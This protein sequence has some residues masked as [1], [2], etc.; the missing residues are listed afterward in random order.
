VSV[1]HAPS[2]ER[3]TAALFE[4]LYADYE[5]PILNYL[6]RLLGDPRLAEDLAQEAFTRAWNARR[7][8]PRLDNPRAWMYR[9]ATNL[10][11]DHFRRARLLSWLP[12][13]GKEPALTGDPH[14]GDPIEAA[15]MRRALLK[16][17]EDYRTPLVLYTCQEFSVAEIAATLNVST[18]AV[19]QR[20]VRAR[21]QLRSVYE[22]V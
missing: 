8:L 17:S 11:R 5:S 20:L 10:A 13:L 14:E 3:E 15:K 1:T 22:T 19:K 9:I 18:D 16:L 6:Y 12:L 2:S 21:Q 4:R 7:D